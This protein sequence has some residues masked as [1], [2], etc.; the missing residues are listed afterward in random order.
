MLQRLLSFYRRHFWSCERHARHLGV[1]IGKGCYI[2]TRKFSSEG[3][4]IEIGNHVRIAPDTAFYTHGGIEP[5]R[6]IYNNKTLDIFGKI[7]IGDYSY[8]GERCMIM[9]GVTIGN[10][11]IIGGGTIVTKSIPDGYMVAGNPCQIIGR[12]ED[13]YNRIKDD[14]NFK[15]KGLNHEKIK[16]IILS[17]DESLFIKKPYLKIHESK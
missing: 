8:I 11:C 1:K 16:E 17:A 14:K 13:F 7:K 6:K 3:F 2:S 12:T 10:N 4:L 15:T 9:P 5:L